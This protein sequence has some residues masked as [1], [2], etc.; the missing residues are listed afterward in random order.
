M[1]EID[2]TEASEYFK[3]SRQSLD[4]LVRHENTNINHNDILDSELPF[5]NHGIGANVT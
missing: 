1:N 2:Y 4:I 3:K 5:E